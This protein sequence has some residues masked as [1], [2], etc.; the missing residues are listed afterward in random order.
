MI[1]GHL[2]VAGDIHPFA[3]LYSNWPWHYIMAFTKVFV[4]RYGPLKKNLTI[5]SLKELI[6]SKIL[7]NFACLNIL[8]YHYS[9]DNK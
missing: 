9:L 4:I 2:A 7:G 3:L 5:N 6:L 8:V 1:D